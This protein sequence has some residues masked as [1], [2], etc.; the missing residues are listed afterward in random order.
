L[1]V[2]FLI[3]ISELAPLK[4]FPDAI[5]VAISGHRCHIAAAIALSLA[6]GPVA[7]LGTP[8]N[9][10]LG[11]ANIAGHCRRRKKDSDDKN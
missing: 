4:S 3:I 6:V 1:D 9:S 2:S 8:S 10:S 7:L 5:G 11:P